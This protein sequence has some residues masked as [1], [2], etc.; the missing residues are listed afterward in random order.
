MSEAVA[1]GRWQ[2]LRAGFRTHPMWGDLMVIVLLSPATLVGARSV[3]GYGHGPVVGLL[4][5]A[6]FTVPL[7]WRRTAPE[8]VALVLLAACTAQLAMGD[9]VVPGD[10]VAPVMVYTVSRYGNPRHA[11]GWL[12][13]GLAGSLAAGVRFAITEGAA[14][15]DSLEGR[16]FR[17]AIWVVGLGLVVLASWLGGQ[18]LRQRDLTLQTLRERAEALEGERDK[19]MRLAAEEERSRIAREMHDVVA[20]SLSVIVVQSDGAG[21]LA[22]HS[23]LA[24]AEARLAQVRQAIATINATAREAL[25]ETRRL[26]GVLRH[27]G[28]DAELAPTAT[29]G[30][31]GDLVDRLGAAG[32]PATF[33]HVGDGFQHEPL[34]PGAEMAL[35]RVAQEALTNV[36]KHA[37]A[38]ARV[39]VTLDEGTDAVELRITDT[40]QGTPASD[41]A[42]HGLVGMRERMAAWDGSLHASPVLD[43]SGRRC[44]F[45]VRARVPAEPVAHP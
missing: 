24:D 5:V 12:G 43:A 40:G 16:L 23:E 31:I 22:E 14:L 18:W 20:H 38:G 19:A 34:A 11:R 26:V 33:T 8:R 44:G 27:P 1:V 37:G 2:R 28:E 13:V 41:S 15:D 30:Q 17:M 45:E 6:L 42:G 36:L 3:T 29:L 21:Y 39:Q 9:F 7:L 10:V 4:G 35:H 25:G 32:V